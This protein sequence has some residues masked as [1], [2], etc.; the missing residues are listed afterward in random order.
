MEIII[1]IIIGII[2]A[3]ATIVV[4][5]TDKIFFVFIMALIFPFSCAVSYRD[6]TG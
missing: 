5:N 6:G 2:A 4:S 1:A 3:K